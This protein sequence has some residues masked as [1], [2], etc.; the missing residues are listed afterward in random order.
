M[1][2]FTLP[3]NSK[4]GPGKT[5]PAPPGAKRV[6]EF[7]IYRW[8]PDDAENPAIDT[9]RSISTSAGRWFSTR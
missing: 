8:N 3:A 9:L 6:R 5:D 7:K 1:G 2:E 4:V